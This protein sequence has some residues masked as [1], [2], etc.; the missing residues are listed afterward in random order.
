MPLKGVNTI[1]YIRISTPNTKTVIDYRTQDDRK[2]LSHQVGF[3]A[4]DGPL[5]RLEADISALQRPT[6]PSLALREVKNDFR[7]FMHFLK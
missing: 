6:A 1:G 4:G 3:K 2:T 5:S 7:L